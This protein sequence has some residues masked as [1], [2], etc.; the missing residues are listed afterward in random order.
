M[1][2][3]PARRHGENAVLRPDHDRDSAVH[4]HHE[5]IAAGTGELQ[6]MS[7]QTGLRK[8][9]TVLNWHEDREYDTTMRGRANMVVAIHVDPA[10]RNGRYAAEQSRTPIESD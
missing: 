10:R 3:L 5:V 2:A 4:T 8:S 7:R 6:S 9:F 1:T